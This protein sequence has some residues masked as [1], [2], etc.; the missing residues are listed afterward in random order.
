MTLKSFR[1]SVHEWADPKIHEGMLR[2]KRKNLSY[3][4]AIE[5]NVKKSD[6]V[7]DIGCGIGILSFFAAKKGC[8]KVYAI[9]NSKIIEAAI[10]TA[11]LNNLDK[12][13]KFIKKDVLKVKL[14]EKIDVI[15][16]EQIGFCLWDEGL[17]PK[18]AYI[19]DNFLKKGGRIIPFKIELYFV[20]TCY[21]S[22]LIESLDFWRRKRYGIDFSNL[23]KRVIKQRKNETR[24]P[25]RILLKNTE[26]FLCKEKLVYTVDLRKERQIPRKIEASFRLKKNSK[27]RG[28]C[29]FF[30]IHLDE[31]YVISTRPKKGSASWGWGQ[32]LLPCF[33]E[34]TVRKDS[35]LNLTA[36]PKE[37]PE[38]WKFTF[39]LG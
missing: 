5:A 18:V 32:F 28:I 22:D 7:L 13:I 38:K 10:E 6:T 19:R 14:K 11:K 16:Q 2:K 12:N 29:A 21:K 30:K 9:E 25:S 4:K 34:K 24:I 15:I 36:F 33:E 8:K 1:K 31:N 35:I 27:L 23:Y 37:K 20:P 17:V 3:K 39:R 26:T